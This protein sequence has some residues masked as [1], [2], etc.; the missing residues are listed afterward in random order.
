[1]RKHNIHQDSNV[2]LANSIMAL[3]LAILQAQQTV[4]AEGNRVML[5]LY[6]G[7]GRFISHKTRNGIWGDG[8]TNAIAEQLQREMPG[9]RGFS[10]VQLRRMR[11]FYE[12]WHH[13]LICSPLANKL[14]VPSSRVSLQRPV[15]KPETE[16]PYPVILGGQVRNLRVFRCPLSWSLNLK[17][18]QQKLKAWFEDFVDNNGVMGE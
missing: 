10:G 17:L 15:D 14:G 6:L 18:L 8:A 4:A 7:I 2:E 5:M 1:M 13:S 3:K 9:L 11:Q 12:E 16:G